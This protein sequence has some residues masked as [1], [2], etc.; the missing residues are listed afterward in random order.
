[1]N[2]RQWSQISESAKDLVR[3]MLM[4]DPAERIT[5]YEALNH[6]WLK[7]QQSSQWHFNV[8][9]VLFSLFIFSA[10]SD[11]T[12]QY[13]NF[14]YKLKRP[15]GFITSIWMH[16]HQVIKIVTDFSC[17]TTE[18]KQNRKRLHVLTMWG[19]RLFTTQ[20]KYTQNVFAVLE[21]GSYLR[22]ASKLLIFV[23]L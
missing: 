22:C 7:V 16:Y 23:K 3:R 12:S 11:L 6:P 17:I 15:W 13:D 9:L 8:T 4:L 10:R 18:L 2:P 1:M 21:S 19:Y 5:V 20:Q 14:I